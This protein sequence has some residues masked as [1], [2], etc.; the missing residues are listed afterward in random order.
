[1]NWSRELNEQCLE[2]PGV[3]QSTTRWTC[4]GFIF[5]NFHPLCAQAFR[6]I[7]LKFSHFSLQQFSPEFSQN[8]L[9]LGGK[10]NKVREVPYLSL[11][12]FS[13]LAWN[14]IC[15]TM[16]GI[17]CLKLLQ[18]EFHQMLQLSV[19]LPLLLKLSVR[20]A[21]LLT[22]LHKLIFFHVYY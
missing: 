17:L 13:G 7:K 4:F 9:L 15:D 12:Y 20:R 18:W 3:A 21:D 10:S 2:V 8:N 6:Y 16:S 19:N 22:L 5:L 1:M 11:C 14:M